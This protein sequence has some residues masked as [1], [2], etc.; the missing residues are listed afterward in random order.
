M[1]R[2]EDSPHI[3]PA[4][5]DSGARGEPLQPI[6][7]LRKDAA[8]ITSPGLKQAGHGLPQLEA[9]LSLWDI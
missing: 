6:A 7:Y 4:R 1:I 5:S 9:S 3:S 2:F 8:Y